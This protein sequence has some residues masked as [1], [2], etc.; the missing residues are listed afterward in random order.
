MVILSRR[1]DK[2]VYIIRHSATIR[3]KFLGGIVCAHV[4]TSLCSDYKRITAYVKYT[5]L[6]KSA[7]PD[8]NRGC[9]ITDVCND[10]EAFPLQRAKA[11]QINKEILTNDLILQ[12]KEYE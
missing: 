12:N 5:N 6:I 4:R 2:I 3:V 9:L 11:Q 10:E 1:H 8:F 7:Y